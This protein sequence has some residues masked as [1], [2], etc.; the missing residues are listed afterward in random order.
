MSSSNGFRSNGKSASVNLMGRRSSHTAEELRELIL[1]A[2]TE[3]INEGGL[4]QLSAR[5]VARR[6][7]YSPGTLYNVFQNLDDLVLTIEGRMLDRLSAKLAQVKTSGSPSD[8]ILEM[9]RVYLRF[10]HDHPRLW[11]LLFEHHLPANQDIPGWYQQ[12]L[13][14]LMGHVEAALA[15]MMP[16]ADKDRVRRA[17]SVLWAGVHGIT[18]L[19]T[20]DKLSTV[21]ADGA[22]A[23]VDDLVRTY[24]HGLATGA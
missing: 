7:G 9:A 21:T 18:S 10:T 20:A 14:G 23:L 2:S 15:P 16:N 8:H 24:L 1:E 6:I 4:A 5:E 19:S 22:S 13:N 17:A 11:N 3:L 12:K